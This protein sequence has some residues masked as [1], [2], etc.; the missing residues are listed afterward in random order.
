MATTT[1]YGWTTPDDTA[2]VKDGAAAIRTLGSSVDSTL[3]TQ[4]DN[5]VA[6]SIQKSLVTTKGDIIAATAA[7]TPARLGV[8]TDGQ[9]L[10]ADSASAAGVK[11]ATPASGGM[12]L[13]STTSFAST[14]TISGISGAYTH[15]YMYIYGLTNA[16]AS[17]SF[18]IA[19][20]GSTTITNNFSSGSATT[21]NTNVNTYLYPVG[22][23]GYL[24]TNS[25]NAYQ[26]TIFNYSGTSGYKTF[27]SSGIFV[28]PAGN[29]RAGFSS[30]G[31][32]TTSAITSLTFSNTG[33]A[34]STG[35][36][37]LYGVK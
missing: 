11:W 32:Q 1:N 37:L 16:T 24:N 7:S 14:T 18:R 35:T 12:T 34:L 5:T 29:Q 25:N 15:L 23:Y 9:F 8:G 33:G 21:V 17:N 20:N 27:L 13:L 10:Q 2:L 19:P 31:I 30:G 26:V 3:K 28:E 22:D 36:C 4:I 6:S